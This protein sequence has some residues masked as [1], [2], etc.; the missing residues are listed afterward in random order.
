MASKKSTK[1]REEEK[2]RA[3]LR[4]QEQQRRQKQA[5][6]SMTPSDLV[7]GFSADMLAIMQHFQGARMH[8]KQ[9]ITQAEMM[10]EQ[11]PE[12]FNTLRIDAFKNLGTRMDELQKQIDGI[13]GLVGTLEDLQTMHD[14]MI[15]VSQ[16]FGSMTEMQISLDSFMR[17]LQDID[18]TFNKTLVELLTP[19]AVTDPNVGLEFPTAGAEEDLTQLIR[20]FG[21]RRP[22]SDTETCIAFGVE[23]VTFDAVP[24]A[25][26]KPVEDIV[27]I[28]KTLVIEEGQDSRFPEDA[29][30]RYVTMR[31]A[32]ALYEGII[33]EVDRTSEVDI[34]V[35]ESEAQAIMTE[36][37]TPPIQDAEMKSVEDNTSAQ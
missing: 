1:R 24:R 16:N 2:K 19:E 8:V 29:T 34:P 3:Q 12:R 31:L 7:T 5:K 14:K 17:E 26:Y 21:I 35:T 20:L 28:T 33:S 11:N 9:R 4:A 6:P 23:S 22:D 25:E 15:F 37:T 36:Q 10:K 27:L 30:R 13:A 32:D 18:T